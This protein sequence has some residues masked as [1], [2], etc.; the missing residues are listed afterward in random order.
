MKTSFKTVFLLVTVLVL[1]PILSAAYTDQSSTA[2]PP[3]SA[4]LI[5]EGTF[6]V[7]LAVALKVGTP[8]NEVEAESMLT[9]AGISPVNGWMADY[10]VTPDIVGELQTAVGRASESGTIT[11]GK[12]E[13]LRSLQGVMSGYSLTLTPDM[14]GSTAVSSGTEYPDPTIVNNYYYDEG[15]PVVTYYAP[16]PDYAYLYSWVPYPFWWWGGFWFPGFF[17]LAD[18]DIHH[19]DGHHHDGHDNHGWHGQNGEHFT[20]HF[21]NAGTGQ[22]SRVD[23]ASRAHGGTFANGVSTGSGWSSASARNGAQ[24]IYNRSTGMTAATG[25][26]SRVASPA[27]SGR[28]SAWSSQSS[29]SAAS[30]SRGTWSSPSSGRTYSSSRNSGGRTVATSPAGGRS[31][32][33]SSFS[34]R[35]FGGSHSFAGSRVSFGGGGRR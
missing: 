11:M 18:F 16:P 23:P 32:S 4:P 1:T 29:G 35:S 27:W 31:F 30:G 2:R 8:A 9:A 7:G 34:G 19:H 28:G 25:A 12:D 14:S 15:P 33:S 10:P 20:N 21:R 5:R 3:V 17:V 13:A 26:G 6:A 22:M 24:Q